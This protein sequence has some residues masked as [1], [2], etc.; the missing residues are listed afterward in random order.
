MTDELVIYE[1]KD[2]IAHITIN[3]PNKRNSFTEDTRRELIDH[4]VTFK[5]D[6]DADVAILTGT[7]DIAWSAGSEVV[8]G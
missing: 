8:S 7:G 2:R 5:H 4:W 6:N 3:R 1:V